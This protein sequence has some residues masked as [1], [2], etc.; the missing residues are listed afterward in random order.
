MRNRASRDSRLFRRARPVP[1]VAFALLSVMSTP[2]GAQQSKTADSVSHD[3]P[4]VSLFR[5]RDL[6]VIAGMAGAIAAAM[7]ADQRIERSFQRP[8]IQ[9][10]RGLKHVSDVSGLL[11][12]PGS[13][14]I[15]AGLYFAGLG[16]HSRRTAALG[17]HTGESVVLGGLLSLG[18]KGELGRARPK[19]SPS[20]SHLFRT[21]KGFSSDGYASM[22]STETTAAFAAAT[23]LSF[24]INR[25]WPG[26]SAVV[27]PLAYTGATL[28]ALSRLYKN[29]HWT[30]DVVAGAGIGVITG[31]FVDR[32]NRRYRD[33]VFEKW[34]LPSSIVPG[35]RGIAVAWTR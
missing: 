35:D 14:I 7:P 25:D 15:S 17:M 32:F 19:F 2:A 10:N 22:P 9:N 21:G 12:D 13:V 26:H 30:S 28:V 23:A 5:S 6:F 33:N 27:T 20:D 29:E 4:R 8:S 16:L 34:F 24:G 31:I 11:G 18:L 1:L 3:R